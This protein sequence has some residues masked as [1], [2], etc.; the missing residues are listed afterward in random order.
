V[1]RPKAVLDDA[2]QT[3][4]RGVGLD[5]VAPGKLAELKEYGAADPMS[6]VAVLTDSF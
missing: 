5:V 3:Y 4:G 6:A 2:D 1:V